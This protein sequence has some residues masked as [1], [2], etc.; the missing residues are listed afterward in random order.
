MCEI[1]TFG[2]QPPQYRMVMQQA[3]MQATNIAK[4][5]AMQMHGQQM[6]SQMDTS[7]FS[8]LFSP[9]SD[10]LP[11]AEPGPE[12]LLGWLGTSSA[13]SLGSLLLGMMDGPLTL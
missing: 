1:L 6:I 11:D 12:V 7:F 13:F 10:D 2:M 9:F 3:A 4:T 5:A 8:G